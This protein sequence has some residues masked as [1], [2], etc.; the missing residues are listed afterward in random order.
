MLR[1][2]SVQNLALI[3]DMHVELEEGYCAGPER[4][5]RERACS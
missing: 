2:L 5:G 4:R 3:E 1:E